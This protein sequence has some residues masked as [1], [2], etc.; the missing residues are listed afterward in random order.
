MAARV[1]WLGARGAFVGFGALEVGVVSS[2][3]RPLPLADIFSD[4]L[5]LGAQL[6]FSREAERHLRGSLSGRPWKE[7]V[8]QSSGA[9][10]VSPMD[11]SELVGSVLM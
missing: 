5:C 9:P 1:V 3:L 8:E 2:P 7:G 6:F 10:R 4:P 11:G